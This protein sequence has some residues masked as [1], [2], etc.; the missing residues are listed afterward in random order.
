[1]ED[2]TP[3]SRNGPRAFDKHFAWQKIFALVAGFAP[4]GIYSLTRPTKMPAEKG[5]MS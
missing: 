1:M 4:P 3:P 2:K 5:S